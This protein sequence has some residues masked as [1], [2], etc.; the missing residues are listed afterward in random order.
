MNTNK[1]ARPTLHVLARFAI[2]VESVDD[3]IGAVCIA[4]DATN[5]DLVVFVNGGEISADLVLV[6]NRPN[7]ACDEL[8]F[9]CFP[10]A[11]EAA[12]AIVREA[13]QDMFDAIEDSDDV[14]VGGDT[15]KP[16]DAF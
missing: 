6:N 5:G 16:A 9:R 7:E 2:G 13:A 10:L 3:G 4:E 12:V 15:F 8:R 14:R 11:L 1:T